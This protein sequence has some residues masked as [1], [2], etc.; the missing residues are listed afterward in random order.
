MIAPSRRGIR[1]RTQRPCPLGR[2]CRSHGRRTRVDYCPRVRLAATASIAEDVH[3]EAPCWNRGA[4]LP[5]NLTTG[6][7]RSVNNGQR[8]RSPPAVQRVLPEEE[9]PAM[10]RACAATLG[11]LHTSHRVRLREKDGAGVSS[12]ENGSNSSTVV[13]APGVRH[14]FLSPS[15]ILSSRDSK[16]RKAV[17][18]RKRPPCPWW[19]SVGSRRHL[20]QARRWARWARVRAALARD[21][22]SRW[23]RTASGCA[24]A[25]RSG[26]ISSSRGWSAC[27]RS[28][29]SR[30]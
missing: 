19:R 9:S 8:S 15:L 4:A 22:S 21:S 14:D 6:K 27:S 2:P 5:G 13:L 25:Q 17:A 1:P 24:A 20:W 3:T 18:G 26:S 16:P 7:R 28:R 30:T 12:A 10:K 11:P 29:S 23:V